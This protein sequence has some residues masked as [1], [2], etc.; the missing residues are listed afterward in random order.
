MKSENSAYIRIFILA[1]LLGIALFVLLQSQ[2]KITK[3]TDTFDKRPEIKILFIGN[4]RTFYHDMPF[5]VRQIADSAND[6]HKYI[7]EMHAPPGVYLQDHWNNPEVTALLNKKWDYVVIQGASAE[8][9]TDEANSNF[10]FYG[11]QLINLA[12]MN[13]SQPV[14]FLSWRYDKDE[15]NYAQLGGRMQESY[16]QLAL[17][18]GT[19]V[20]N[21]SAYWERLRDQNQ[22]I[23]LYEDGN[24]P[25]TAGSYLTAL[26]FYKFFSN[27]E[28]SGVRYCPI[29][30]SAL[31][32]SVIRSVAAQSVY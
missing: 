17:D 27:A 1:F 13:G 19:A 30:I 3:I 11:K 26:V 15:H 16:A 23:N 24:H 4:S 21:V 28:I 29:E 6:P 5:M 22:S 32:A 8:Q 20:V 14:L 10:L 25:S 12:K 9:M 31:N 18:T 7:I 2:N